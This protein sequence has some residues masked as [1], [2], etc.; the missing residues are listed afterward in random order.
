MSNNLLQTAIDLVESM[1]EQDLQKFNHSSQWHVT[2][3]DFNDKKAL[4]L[5]L[6]LEIG[7]WITRSNIKEKPNQVILTALIADLER[8]LEETKD[9]TP[10]FL[11][12]LHKT[13]YTEFEPNKEFKVIDKT[14]KLVELGKG[15]G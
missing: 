8:H 5:G 2:I 9:S 7:L 14:Y 3:G 4:I 10:R 15:E 6:D 12:V 11:V 1:T 13:V